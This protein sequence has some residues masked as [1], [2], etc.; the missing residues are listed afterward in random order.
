MSYPI[1][2]DKRYIP[3]IAQDN[4]SVDDEDLGHMNPLSADFI[5]LQR[6]TPPAVLS[7]DD[8][9]NIGVGKA[10]KISMLLKDPHYNRP[11]QHRA[12]AR[13]SKTKSNVL[14]NYPHIKKEIDI[15][16]LKQQEKSISDAFIKPLTE[17]GIKVNNIKTVYRK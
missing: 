9:S 5:K 16:A 8:S 4:E 12:R 11:K 1:K 17:K 13:N 3:K 2:K 10:S 14:A 15:L 6:I 7:K